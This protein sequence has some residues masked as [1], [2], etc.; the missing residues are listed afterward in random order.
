ML[1]TP[2]INDENVSNSYVSLVSPVWLAETHDAVWHQ[3][4]MHV[5]ELG[6][7]PWT[8]WETKIVFDKVKL[9]SPLQIITLWLVGYRSIESSS[10]CAEVSS[11]QE[12]ADRLTLP[13]LCGIWLCVLFCTC[14]V[15]NR[16]IVTL[17]VILLR[18]LQVNPS[19]FLFSLIKKRF[20]TVQLLHQ[21][22]CEDQFDM[23]GSPF[24]RLA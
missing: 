7:T 17:L 3:I 14:Q 6:V 11:L 15:L 5:R 20:H 10:E 21:L 13:Y 9:L 12:T 2:K 4:N 1:K 23:T 8:M 19:A 22:C 16:C 18:W 24:I